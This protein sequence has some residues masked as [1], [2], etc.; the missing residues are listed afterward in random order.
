MLKIIKISITPREVPYL[1]G[2]SMQAE[3]PGCRL[4]LALYWTHWLSG[5][6]VSPSDLRGSCGPWVWFSSDIP[7]IS[8][9]GAW[10]V[11]HLIAA[12]A[13]KNIKI[14]KK[15]QMTQDRQNKSQQ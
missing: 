1:A 15:T 10:V 3:D 5:N 13:E 2:A 4:G 7:T 12:S 11:P 6:S 9:I 8:P 14:H